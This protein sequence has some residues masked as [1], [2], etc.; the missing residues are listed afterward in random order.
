MARRAREMAERHFDVR[1]QVAR[2]LAVYHDAI[3]R[4][5]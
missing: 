5:R 3:A 1:L 4:V 2:T